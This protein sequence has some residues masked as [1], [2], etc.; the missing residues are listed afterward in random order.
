ML[1]DLLPYPNGPMWRMRSLIPDR[2]GKNNYAEILVPE[3]R[4]IL[5]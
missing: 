3:I 4:A 5:V 1:F 2:Y